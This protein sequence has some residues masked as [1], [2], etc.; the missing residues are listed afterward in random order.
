MA[1]LV[2]D[3]SGDFIILSA[4]ERQFGARTSRRLYWEEVEMVVE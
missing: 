2:V 4:L 3:Q 1:F